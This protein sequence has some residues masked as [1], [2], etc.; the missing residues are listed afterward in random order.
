M[1]MDLMEASIGEIIH[2]KGPGAGNLMDAI[3]CGCKGKC[4]PKTSL[5]LGFA[6]KMLGKEDALPELIIEL[7]KLP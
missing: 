5:T 2:Q 6:A 4:C 1:A 3:L 7:E